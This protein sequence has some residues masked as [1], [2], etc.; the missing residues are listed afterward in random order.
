MIIRVKIGSTTNKG[1]ELMLRAIGERLGQ[2]HRLL[3]EGG[4][5]DDRLSREL[6]L[7]RLLGSDVSGPI[8][9]C[10]RLVSRPKRTVTSTL[11][12]MS[13]RPKRL[14][15]GY[16]TAGD[17]GA[18]LDA[19]GF[20]Y[21][22]A[23]GAAR[24][25][26]MAQVFGAYKRR[27][28]PV[29]L[30]PQSFG[31]F[32]D[33]ELADAFRHL[34]DHV[35]LVYA[36]DRQSFE[37]LTALIGNDSR[38]REA[39]DYTCPVAGVMPDGDLGQR[40][41]ACIIPNHRMLDSTSGET[42]GRYLSFLRDCVQGLQ[43]FDLHP[44]I[45]LHDVKHDEALALALQETVGRSLEIIAEQDARIVKGVI[46]KSRLLISSRFHGLMNGLSQEI[47]CI[48]TEW[49]HKFRELMRSFGCEDYL[50]SPLESPSVLEEKI[51][52]LVEG[53]E[54]EQALGAIRRASSRMQDRV[55]QMWQEIEQVLAIGR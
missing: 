28:K 8:L 31:P 18:V 10:K 40:D 2:N 42:A 22:D 38:I 45:V 49:T 36:R 41:Y 30:L 19:S 4:K 14:D 35:D 21:G 9:F 24:A 7:Y 17:A 32:T 26:Q 20:V 29:V 53:P 23:W 1:D 16:A 6:G 54:R 5:V 50:V 39:P 43:K 27:G 51:G 52:Q 12:E 47:P 44:V 55:A 15:L 37:H 34:V 3:V 13:L 46:G 33:S 48:A 25:V 11:H